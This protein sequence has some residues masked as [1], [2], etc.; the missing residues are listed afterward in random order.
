MDLCN[1]NVIKALLERHGF[2]FS[3]ALGQNFLIAPWVPAR[4][5]EESLADE[6]SAVLEIGPGVGC[7]TKELSAVSGKVCAV[8]L[9]KRLPDVLAESLSDCTNVEIIQGDILKTD[10]KSL[11]NDRF[12]SLTPRVCANLPYNI[13]TP[14]ISKLID[15]GIFESI[16]V[17]IQRE[18]AQRICAENGS[19]DYGAFSVYV[20]YHTEP[21]ILFDVSPDCFIPRPNVTS[22]VIRLIKRHTPP[23]NVSDETLFF[24]IVRAAFS[25]RRKTLVNTLASAFPNIGKDDITSLIESCGIDPRIRGE[26]LAIADF[27][28]VAEKI[29]SYINET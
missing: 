15:S 20:N 24:K 6:N 17:M 26:V 28:Q 22:T 10:I 8:E 18:V 19:G 7:L 2:R 3:K 27:A 4:I 9:D 14:A 1:I 25:Q 21:E 13:T 5:A 11:V 23:V 29:G 12:G 16:T